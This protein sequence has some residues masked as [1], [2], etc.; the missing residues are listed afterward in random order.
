MKDIMKLIE[1]LKNSEKGD[2]EGEKSDELIQ[3]AESFLETNIPEN[4]KLFLKNLG[5]GDINGKEIYGIVRDEFVDSS[6]PNM[7]WFTKKMRDEFSAP[8]KYLFIASSDELYYVL[9]TEKE[10]DGDAPVLRLF[11]D[12]TTEPAFSSFVEFL[13][14]YALENN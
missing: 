12:G 5:C 14:K 11:M 1:L 2:F 4:Y 3:K 10:Q 7:V 6:V 9:D 13:D 8:K